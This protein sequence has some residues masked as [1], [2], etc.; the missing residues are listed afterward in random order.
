M[1]DRQREHLELHEG[2][3]HA[4]RRAGGRAVAQGGEA[5]AEVAAPQG[6]EPDRGDGERSG[7]QHEVG[8]IA[9]EGHSSDRKPLD[10]DRPEVA[11]G[12]LADE[13]NVVHERGEGQRGQPEIEALETQGRECHERPHDRR[14][15]GRDD[16]P[17]RRAVGGHLHA[18]QRSDAGEGELAQR[19]LAGPTRQRDQ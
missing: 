19:H 17:D 7:E 1:A 9:L 10:V 14:G 12:V 5:A 13:H 4:H 8:S 11:E 6:Q 18:G 2:G 16:E 3:A 15:Q